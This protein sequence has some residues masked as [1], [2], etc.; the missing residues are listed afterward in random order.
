MS[1][2]YCVAPM[3]GLTGLPFRRVHARLFA[4]ADKYFIPFVTPT[5]EPRFTER[6][7]RELR[8]ENNAGLNV[9]PQLLT[10]RSADFIWAAKALADMGY[11]EVNLNLGCPA[12]TVVARGKGAGFL[13]KPAELEHFLDEI[14]SADLPIDISVK[15][16]IG[17][18]DESEFDLLADVYSHFPMKELII[19]PRLRKEFYKGSV[20]ENI[21]E[22]YYSQLP[23]PLGYNG[24][25]ITGDDIAR[26]EKHY[27][28][29]SMVMVGR[30][31]MADPALFRKA[32]SG[33]PA[34][35]DEII[36][37]C[38]EI[39]DSYHSAFGNLKNALMRMKE[40]W[41]YQHNLFEGAEKPVKNVFKAK[42]LQ[43]YESAIG[44]IFD[45]CPLRT[46]AA[47]GWKKPL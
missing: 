8:P 12:G 7:L 2:L 19:H 14:F 47:F 31:L 38:H 13:R 46:E 42:T 45:H 36:R 28:A 18:A 26:I 44:Y 41:F 17:W 22:K 40:Y 6:Q 5:V 23:M 3:E 24:D 1:I 27:P 4:G 37:F 39:L 43:E 30:A 35:L 34:E 10:Q 33:K 25:V 15:T 11:G 9:V 29:L 21:F 20:H 16:R 32:R